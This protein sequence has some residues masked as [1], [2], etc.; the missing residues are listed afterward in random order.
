MPLL[1]T[2]FRRWHEHPNTLMQWNTILA[3]A[4]ELD[5]AHMEVTT[6]LEYLETRTMLA[7]SHCTFEDI[8]Q[9]LRLIDALSALP[10]PWDWPAARAALRNIALFLRAG[11]TPE[12][13]Q[14]VLAQYCELE[15][16]GFD[17]STAVAVGKA[18]ALARAGAVETRR[19]AA[20]KEMASLA[21]KKVQ[22]Q[23]LEAA[24]V[25]LAE[26]LTRLDAHHGQLERSVAEMTKRVEAL[27]RQEVETRQRLTQLEGEWTDKAEDLK[28]LRALRTFLLRKN[29]AIDAFF[30]D[31]DRVRQYRTHVRAP[32]RYAV[33]HLEEVRQQVL[34]F[35]QRIAEEG[36]QS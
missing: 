21:V 8:P 25:T 36:Q 14:V 17:G 20:L 27:H 23:L 2:F 15:E 7:Q 10:T 33:L 35:M 26:G 19:A 1:I 6:L 34:G 30:S 9:A 18:L 22:V 13:I 4:R 11:I 24:Q 28:V 5:L 16:L 12:Q 31:M 29:A 3:S 32:D